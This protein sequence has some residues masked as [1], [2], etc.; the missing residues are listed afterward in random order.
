MTKEEA[1]SQIEE[2]SKELMHHNHQYYVLDNPEISDYDFDQKL[3]QLQKLEEAFP[4]FKLSTSPTQRVGGDVTKNFETVPHK[5]RMLSLANTY[6]KEELEDFIKRIGKSISDPVEFVCE[7][8]YDGAAIGITY[9]NGILTRALTRG[10]GTQGDDITANVRTIRSI[11]LQLHGNDFPEELEIRGE[12][13]MLLEGFAKLNQQRIED[14]EEPFA[15]PRNTASG[16]LKMQD[17]SI[18]ASRSLDCFLYYILTDDRMFD[19]H[20]ESMQK[21]AQWGFK[22]PSAEKNY[23]AKAKNVDEIFDFINYWEE[24][25]HELPFEID[26]IVVKV[27][28]YAQQDKLGFTAKSPRWAISYKYKAEQVSTKLNSITYQVGRTGAITPVANLEPVQLAGTTV[29]RASLHN[30]DQIEKLD[31]RVGDHVYVEKGGE[32]IPKVIGVDFDQRPPDLEPVKYATHCPECN[33]ELIRKEGEAQHYCPNDDGCPPQIKGRIQHFI[34]RKAMDIEGMGGETVDQFV[35]EGLISNYADLYTLQKEQLLPLERMA[36]KSAQNIIEGIEASKSIPFERVL[37]GLGIRYV[38]ETVAKKLARHFANI[39][40]LMAAS[41]EEL[42]NVDEIGSRIAESVTTFFSDPAK[43]GTVERMKLAGLQFEVV[44]QEGESTKLDGKTIVI[45]GNFERY[46]RK[47]IKELIEKH[48]GKNTGSVSGKT[49]LI[50]AGEGMG[51]SKRKKAEDLG[52]K[53]IDENEFAEL[54][55]D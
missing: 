20:F 49:D 52:V 21:A 8:K 12:I 4:E 14:G 54:I 32:I 17:S 26:G 41:L 28:D 36:E 38:G 25:R 39:D 33:T 51:P 37:F 35:N 43:V 3:K 24:H 6:S 23:I 55:G 15:N 30:A 18:V 42:T 34:S 47:E 16:T 46:S 1:K 7:L 45:S 40:T 22:V 48:G 5:T 13:F 44:Q 2:L 11:P 10:D 50:V 27:N 29:K 9:K 53:I 19:N 31:L